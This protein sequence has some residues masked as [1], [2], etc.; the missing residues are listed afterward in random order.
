VIDPTFSVFITM[1]P[2]YAGR[3]QLPDNLKALFRGVSMII[4]D[5]SMIVEI[6]LYSYGFR[7]CRPLARKIVCAFRLASEQLSHRDHYDYGMRAIKSSL[8]LMGRLRTSN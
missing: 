1:N 2:G 8:A 7:N 3:T 5:F 6:T 4:P